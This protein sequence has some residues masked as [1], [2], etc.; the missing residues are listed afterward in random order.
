MLE[1]NG[2]FREVILDFPD[3]KSLVTTIGFL[4]SVLM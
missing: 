4:G 1:I 3:E 2:K